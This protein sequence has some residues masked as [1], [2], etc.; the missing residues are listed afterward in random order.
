MANDFQ[1]LSVEINCEKLSEQYDSNIIPSL[2]QFSSVVQLYLTLCDPMGCNTPGFPITNSQAYSTSC[3]SSGWCHPVI[4]SSVI[5]FFSLLQS[6]PASGSFQVSQF[7]ASG[8]Q[9]IEV[10]PSA[11]VLSMNIQNWFSLGLIRLNFLLPK[12]LSRVFFNTTEKKH[13]FFSA[14]SCYGPTLTSIHDY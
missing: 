9:S 12:G 2:A 11:S 7:F 10:S 14:Q 1:Q 13:Q 6:F 3:P 8:G 5:P 4:S